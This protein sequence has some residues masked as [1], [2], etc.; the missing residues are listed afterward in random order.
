MLLSSFGTNRQVIGIGGNTGQAITVYVEVEPNE[1]VSKESVMLPT[2]TYTQITGTW[3]K[4][5]ETVSLKLGRNAFIFP[6]IQTTGFYAIP[7]AKGG[8]I[9]INNPYTLETQGGHVNLYIEGGNIY[10]VFRQGDDEN[11]FR[12]IL[13]N[14]YDRLN[15]P[16]DEE[17]TVDA[18]E[19]YS[20]HVITSCSCTL[21]YQYYIEKKL[22][23]TGQC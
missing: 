1:G 17:I 9:H 13:K 23:T 7:I 12:I 11:A 4:S 6:D 8:P 16:N 21:A 2:L 5:F 14:Y 19:A 15:D 22:F 10:T 18:F 20:N 3:Q